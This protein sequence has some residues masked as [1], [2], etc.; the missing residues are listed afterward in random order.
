MVGA[1]TIIG[2]DG[3]PQTDWLANRPERFGRDLA[4]VNV[5]GVESDAVAEKWSKSKIIFNMTAPMKPGD[6][7]MVG[8][9][10]YGTEKATPLG[11]ESHP[12]YGKMTRG[13]YTGKS[14]RVKFS[15]SHV[16]SVR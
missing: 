10:Y 9:Y 15:T 2:P 7:P 6:Y 14:G 8:V 13:T 3:S 12:I 5:T 1:P 16:I 11:Y 4:Y